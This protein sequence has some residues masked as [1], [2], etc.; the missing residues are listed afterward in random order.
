[1]TTEKVFHNDQYLKTLEATIT[2][3]VISRERTE[4]ITDR[5]IFFAEGGG[6]PGDRGTIHL[7]D[8][9]SKTV[10]IFDTHDSGDAVA[11][12]TNDEVPFTVGDKVTLELDWTFRFTNM[13]RHYGEHILSGAIYKLYKGSNKGFHMGKNYITIDIDLGGELMTEEML[14][15]SEL[16]ANEAVWKNLPIQAHH[17]DSVE[18]ANDM[19]LRKAVNKK[20]DGDVVVVT[21][22]DPENPFDCCAC[23]GTYPSFSG[24]VGVI[25]IFKAEPNKGMTRIYFDCGRNALLHYRESHKI[26]TEVAEKFSSKPENLMHA[27]AKKDKEEA[28]LNAE[29]A[30]LAEYVRS[31][32]AEAIARSHEVGMNFLYKEYDNISP[33]DLQ[34]LGFKAL[35]MIDG[36]KPLLALAN[37]PSHTLMLVS[38]GNHPC[39]TLVKEHAKN[40]GGKGGGRDD[41]ARAQFDSRDGLESF[42]EVIKQNL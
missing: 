15:E 9:S 35:E 1:M 31:F 16:L 39:G 10:T 19:P 30:S 28:E 27:I 21:V 7:S 3:I 11:H 32:E 6:Q 24:E 36:E 40:F 38:D 2:D 26:L 20:V 22:G 12:Y 41:N 17:F 29:R 25:K 14:S 4:I 5:T 18:A 23:C 34:K 8:D 33:N 37:S 13:Q 42:V